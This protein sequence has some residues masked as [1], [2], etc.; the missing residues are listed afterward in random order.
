MPKGDTISVKLISDFSVEESNNSSII[1]ELSYNSKVENGSITFHFDSSTPVASGETEGPQNGDIEPPLETPNALRHEDDDTSDHLK[2]GSQVD[3]EGPQNVGIEQTPIAFS[4][5]DDDTS[6][7]LKVSSQVETEE[8]Q[9]VDIEPPLETLNAFS[10]EDDD[11]S[12]HLKVSSQ[13]ERDHGESSF[14]TFSGLITI[15]GPIA[16]SGSLSH[17]SDSSATSTRSFAFP[18]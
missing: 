16:Y 4:H 2:V 12:D 17:R 10:H 7:H 9:N 15:S 6:D 5:E 18:M 14:T 13:I 1:D 3:T 11:T 8:P